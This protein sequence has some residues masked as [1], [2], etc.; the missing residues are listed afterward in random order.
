MN[1]MKYTIEYHLARQIPIEKIEDIE[2][3]NLFGGKLG[4]G[5]YITP[6]EILSRLLIN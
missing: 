4:E 3:K 1:D 6:K 5:D 2:F